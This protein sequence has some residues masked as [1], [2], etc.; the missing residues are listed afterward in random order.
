MPMKSIRCALTLATSLF[1]PAALPAGQVRHIRLLRR[2]IAAVTRQPAQGRH[3]FCRQFDAFGIDG[4]TVV[5]HPALAG[6]HIK[7]AAG[8]PGV[9]DGALLILDLLEAAAAAASAA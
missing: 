9:E 1:L 2:Y 6:D 7:I 4:K 8:G 3:Q 5:I